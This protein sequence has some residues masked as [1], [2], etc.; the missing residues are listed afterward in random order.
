MVWWLCTSVEGRFRLGETP[1]AR[2]SK[3][4]RATNIR[5]KFGEEGFPENVY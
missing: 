1:W 2:T 4:I 5:I 3:V